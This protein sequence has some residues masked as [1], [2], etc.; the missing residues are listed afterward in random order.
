[1]PGVFL[2]VFSVPRL[3]AQARAANECTHRYL[4][5]L[6]LRR[7]PACIAWTIRRCRDRTRRYH[8]AQSML[9]PGGIRR[10]EDAGSRGLL[11]VNRTSVDGLPRLLRPVTPRGSQHPC[12]SGQSS[13]LSALLQDRVRFLPVLSPLHPSPHLRLGDSVRGTDRESNGLTTVRRL[14][15]QTGGRAPLDPGGNSTCVGRPVTSPAPVPPPLLGLAPL[16]RLSSA[17]VTVRNAK[18]SLTLPF[19]VIPRSQSGVRLAV[20]AS[21]VCLRPPRYQGRPHSAGTEGTPSWLNHGLLAISNSTT[22]DL[23]SQ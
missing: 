15:H 2:P 13:P 1:M 8:P 9:C 14:Y 21:A 23:V 16:S 5:R 11:I 22:C 10:P 17:G 18:A 7:A 6:T 3:T 4:K 19:P 12:G 20:P